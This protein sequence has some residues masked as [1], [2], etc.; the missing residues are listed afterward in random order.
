MELNTDNY[1]PNWVLKLKS[2]IRPVLTYVFTILYV[3][4]FFKHDDLP[5]IY[6][7]KLS[8]IMIVIIVFWFGER[9]LRNTGVTDFLLN[10]VKKKQPEQQANE[11]K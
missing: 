9:L 7:D 1:S 6:I 4:T 8:D 10:Y 5:D 3:Y 11:L 2:S